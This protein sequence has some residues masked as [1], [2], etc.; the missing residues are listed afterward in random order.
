VDKCPTIFAQRKNRL[1][2]FKSLYARQFRCD[3]LRIDPEG[4]AALDF[5]H[6]FYLRHPM[7]Y[8]R[9][10]CIKNIIFFLFKDISNRIE[11]WLATEYHANGSVYDYLTHHTITI[12]VLIKMMSGIASGLCYLHLQINATNGLLFFV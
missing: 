5:H 9:K 10:R 8:R 3:N 11:L 6:V 1:Q 4:Q 12:P 2:S 7:T